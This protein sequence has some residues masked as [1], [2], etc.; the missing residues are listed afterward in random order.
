[1]RNNPQILVIDDEKDVCDIFKKALTQEGYTVL[2]ALDGLSGLKTVKEKKPDIVLLDLKMPKMDGIEVLRHI[3]K[4]DKNIV[5]IIITGYGTMD[6]ARVAMKLGAFDYITK[7]IDIDYVNA[8][9]LSS[10]FQ[11]MEKI[12]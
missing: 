1:M 10:F 12:P 3:K 7:L 6:T 8:V 4:I 11:T 5:V 9:F 2:T